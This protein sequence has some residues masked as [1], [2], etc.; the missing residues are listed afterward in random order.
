MTGPKAMSNNAQ[1]WIEEAHLLVGQ[2]YESTREAAWAKDRGDMLMALSDI[3]FKGAEI[4][5]A[6]T[7]AKLNVPF[8]E[9]PKGENHDQETHAHNHHRH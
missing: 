6:L 3:R 1:A 2:I 4:R 5:D 9:K 7:N 8:E